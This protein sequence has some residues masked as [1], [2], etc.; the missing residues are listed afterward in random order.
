MREAIEFLRD[1][2]FNPEQ[3]QTNQTVN[4]TSD[5]ELLD[6]YS[7]AVI[8]AAERVSPSVVYIEVQQP[9][10]NRRANDFGRSLGINF[11]QIA[12]GT[13]RI[14]HEMRMA[15]KLIKE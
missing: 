8:T 2:P 4:T 9:G 1:E 7:R 14:Y 5:D 3:L 15:R 10:S 6:A 12:T 11:M 13:A